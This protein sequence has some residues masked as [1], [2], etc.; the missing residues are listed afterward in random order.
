M[1]SCLARTFVL[2]LLAVTEALSQFTD[3]PSV[4]ANSDGR[5]E[6]FARSA[7][8][9]VWHNWQTSPGGSWSGWNSLGG[10]ISGRPA[11]TI[12][13][14]GRLDVF[15]LGGGNT[16]YHNYQTSPGG[17]WSGWISL[18]GSIASPPNVAT[19]FDGRFGALC[20][21]NG[22]GRMAR[23]AANPRQ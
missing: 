15:V 8:G 11:A 14:D 23:I 4:V 19:N 1:N 20:P 7:D 21:R 10:W 9:A 6:I 5:L 17:G 12:N 3:G 2:S 18:G 22:W 16:V 13:A